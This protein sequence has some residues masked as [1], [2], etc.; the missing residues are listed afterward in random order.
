MVHDERRRL[1]TET[2]AEPVRPS[3]RDAER[4]GRS[5][6]LVVAQDDLA[7]EDT[8]LADEDEPTSDDEPA[9]PDADEPT[10]EDPPT[11]DAS[12]EQGE[13]R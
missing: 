5:L 1:G 11:G 4:A 9:G 3:Q 8:D 7:G 2:P 12:T 6:R 10:V 13:A